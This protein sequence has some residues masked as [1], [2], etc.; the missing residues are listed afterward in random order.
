M[1]GHSSSCLDCF[2]LLLR[3]LGHVSL[4]PAPYMIVPSA[5]GRNLF[6]AVTVAKF[7]V[8]VTSCHG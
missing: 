7:R 2:R 4:H 1:G 3:K 5:F 6:L 8:E